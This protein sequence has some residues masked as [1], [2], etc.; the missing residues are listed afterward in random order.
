VLLLHGGLGHMACFGGL[1]RHLAE[2]G[3]SV[4]LVDSRGLGRLSLGNGL[5]YAA[6]GQEALAVLHAL[7]VPGCDLIGLSDGGVVG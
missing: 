2:R 7:G 3:R 5:S 4:L 6:Q 1:L